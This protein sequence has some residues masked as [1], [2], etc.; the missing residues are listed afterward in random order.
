[1]DFENAFQETVGIEGGYVN[2][3]ND[4]GGETKFGIS[5]RSYPAL[6]IA[7]LTMEQAQDIYRRDFWERLH[8]YNVHNPYVSAEIFDT[9]VNCGVDTA[10]RVTQ[11]AL[12]FLEKDAV[13]E[14]GVFGSKSM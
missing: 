4:P 9:A 1:M 6:D 2:D 14:D 7:A 13:K 10:A 11:R 12:R 5:K 3:P 8:L